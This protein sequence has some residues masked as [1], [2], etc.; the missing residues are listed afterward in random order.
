MAQNSEVVHTFLQTRNLRNCEIRRKF[1]K[2]FLYQ[3]KIAKN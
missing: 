3:I 1:P 2:R